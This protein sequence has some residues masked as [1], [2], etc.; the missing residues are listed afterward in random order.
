MKLIDLLLKL[1]SLFDI[2]IKTDNNLIYKGEVGAIPLGI[3]R[4]YGL[5]NNYIVMDIITSPKADMVIYIKEV[6]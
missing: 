2:E 3:V 6:D 4:E 1:E 5:Y